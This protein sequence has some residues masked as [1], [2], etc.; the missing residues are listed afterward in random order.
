VDDADDARPGERRPLQTA[1]LSGDRRK[2]G[3]GPVNKGQK[4]H[5]LSAANIAA[6][7]RDVGQMI[8]I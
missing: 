3:I 2:T 5:G 4:I 7:R 6:S 8:R 1:C